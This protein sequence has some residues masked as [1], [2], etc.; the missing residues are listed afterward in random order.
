MQTSAPTK[1]HERLVPA[2][3]RTSSGL[4]T[5]SFRVRDVWHEPF[6]F[7]RNRRHLAQ[8]IR[9]AALCELETSFGRAVVLVDLR[10]HPRLAEA[11]LLLGRLF[12]TGTRALRYVTLFKAYECLEPNPD[13]EFAAIRH[14]L[15]HASSK[16][17]KPR[18]L[19]VLRR[20]FK[21]VRV[22]LDKPA[23]ARAYYTQFV[24]LLAE[25]DRL[26][27]S[28]IDRNLRAFR[29]LTSRSDALH[30]AQV[31]GWPGVVEPIPVMAR[32]K[33]K[34]SD[35]PLQPTASPHLPFE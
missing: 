28:A 35:R 24:R 13:V 20:L 14:A 31:T 5:A 1:R 21:G 7:V 27:H 33:R 30:V 17:S 16:L 25:V 10:K 32:P 8:R 19:A 34:R 6:V 9:P 26:V 4:L 18:T 2:R 3:H 15:S 12:S 22:N 23:H 11:L 29:V